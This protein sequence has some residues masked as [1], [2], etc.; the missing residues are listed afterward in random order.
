MSLRHTIVATLAMGTL[1]LG[2]NPSNGN[3]KADGRGDRPIG[4][5]AAGVFAPAGPILL[6]YNG[7]PVMLGQTHIYYIWY[8][9]WNVDPK[10]A[11]ILNAFANNIAGSSHYNILTQYSQSPGGNISNSVVFS[12]S[13]NSTYAAA[14]PFALSDRDILGI[15]K[16]AISNNSLPLDANGVYFV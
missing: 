10:G 3:G 4:T 15:V 8:G 7:G 14:Q 9:N 5:A 16:A 6:N 2:Q 11:P 13:T 1:L 12:G